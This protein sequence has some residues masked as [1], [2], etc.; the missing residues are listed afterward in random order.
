VRFPFSD[1][2]S[3]KLR[4]ALILAS[5]A[6]S[7]YILCQI[8]SKLHLNPYAVKISENYYETGTLRTLSYIRADKIF[9]AN[10]VLIES[11][12]ASISSAFYNEIVE[13]ILHIISLEK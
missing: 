8:T 10:G 7:D 5:L 11:K 2:S 3:A 1:L 9:T 12:I 6:H 4:P 13:K